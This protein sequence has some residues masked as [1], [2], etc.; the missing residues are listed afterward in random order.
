MGFSLP[1]VG[2]FTGTRTRNPKRNQ[3]QGE[4][5][6][7]QHILDKLSQNAA[8][9]LLPRLPNVG[10]KNRFVCFSLPEVGESLCHK[11]AS[12]LGVVPD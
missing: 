1:Q 6:K 7:T 9:M 2:E 12:L 3:V 5:G 11:W 8:T 10:V 4:T